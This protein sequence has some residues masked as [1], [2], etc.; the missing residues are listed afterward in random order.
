VFVH[1]VVIND[2]K[3]ETAESVQEI[4]R[5]LGK[6]AFE[7]Q[8]RMICGSPV[9]LASFADPQQAMTL[10]KRVNQTG[11]AAIVVDVTEFRRRT[12][13]IIVRHFKLNESS[14]HIES[15]D[16]RSAEIPY[17]K[18]D[19]LLPASDSVHHSEIKTTTE[20]KFSIGKTLLTGGVPMFKTV[21]HQQE[22]SSGKINKV[23]YLYAAGRLQPV[24]F[25]QDS[26]DFKGLGEDMQIS[27]ELNFTYL[28][29]ELHRLAPGAAYDDRLIRR[30]GQVR[31]LG[32]TLNPETNMDLAVEILVRNLRR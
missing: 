31:L 9:V 6:T 25:K 1:L 19:I 14:L 17:E 15:S 21:K 16:K 5:V 23:L 29:N 32:P 2:W 24:I 28:I 10:A 18:I 11:I 4:S 26:I 27:T 30:A 12:G 13:S 8:Q 20:R 3:E 7:V 22:V